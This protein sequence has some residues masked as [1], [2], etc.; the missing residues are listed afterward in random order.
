MPHR[1]VTHCSMNSY[2]KRLISN[3]FMHGASD[4][5][6]EKELLAVVY[7]FEKFWPYL[8][9]SKSIVYTDHSALKYLFNKQDAKPRL[10]QD[11][12]LTKEQ[13]LQRREALL[14]GLPPSC[15]KCVRIKSS[16]CVFTARKPLIFLRLA[17]MDPS[18]DIMARTT[19]PKKGIDFMG[20][21]PS[22]RGNKYILVTVDYLSK[23]V[24]EKALPTNDTR[25]VCKFLKSLFARFRTP[26]AIISDR[27]THFCNDQF[28]K[29]MLKYG[30]THRLATAYHPQTSGFGTPVPSSVIAIRT[31]AMT[32]L[33][34]SCLSTVSLTVLL[35]R[36]T[37]K[38]VGRKPLTF[39]RL[40]IIDPSGDIMARTTPPKRCLTPVSIGPQSIV[41]PTTWLNLVT[42][43]NVEERFHNEMKCHKDPSKFARFL[44]F[45]ASIS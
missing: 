18:G 40:A 16:G 9:L 22:S 29:V 8:V 4:Y 44:T 7:T 14:L 30:V 37:P 33:Q 17:T 25:V 35:P 11:F 6:T 20:S 23:W 32:S 36:I 13:I 31:F 3:V 2:W 5:Y 15:L 45:G 19:P 28:A 38:Q 34:R 42:L 21:F 10:L 12:I 1:S 27:D 39:S 24:E 43:V 26:R 41:M